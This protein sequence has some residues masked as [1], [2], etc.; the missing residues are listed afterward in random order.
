MKDKTAVIWDL[1]TKRYVHSLRGHE[2]GVQH[3]AINHT[4]VKIL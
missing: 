2:S 3:I 1:N 4:T